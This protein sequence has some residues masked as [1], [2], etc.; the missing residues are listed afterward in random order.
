VQPTELDHLSV[1]DLIHRSHAFPDGNAEGIELL[2]RAVRLADSQGDVALGWEARDALMDAATMGGYPEKTLVAF[3]WN[4]AQFDRFG[5]EHGWD[6]HDLLWKYKWVINSLWSFP[7]IQAAQI[8][9][10][11][12]DFQTRLERAGYSP[13]T[14]YYFR[15]KYAHAR[16]DFHDGDQWRTVWQRAQYD[17]MSDCNACEASFTVDY[18]IDRGD[19]DAALEAATPIL[20]GRMRCA[21]VPHNT[22]ARVLEPMLRAGR[23]DDALSAHLCG[24]RMIQGNQ[25]FLIASG[26]HLAFLAYTHNLPEA[27]KLFERHLPWALQTA[28]PERRYSFFKDALVLTRRL[29]DAGTAAVQLRLPSEF[30]VARGADGYSLA[31]LETY[32]RGEATRIAQAFDARNGNTYFTDRLE[33]DEDLLRGVPNVNLEPPESATKNRGKA[34]RA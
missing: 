14:L 30:S 13:R 29:R 9:A 18:L 4:L 8:E 15:A 11:F 21:E 6:E 34:K 22:L 25:E 31:D 33:P 20:G 26:Q 3:T 1:E 23:T 16:G 28:D 19:T 10:A 7:T 32:L 17:G 5:D 27:V 12:A 24:Y 2:E